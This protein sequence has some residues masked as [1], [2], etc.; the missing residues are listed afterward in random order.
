[1]TLGRC[2]LEK[3]LGIQIP[4]PGSFSRV[5]VAK[6]KMNNVVA[7]A[8]EGHEIVR[9]AL[10]ALRDGDDVMHLVHRGQPTFFLAAFT[11]RV[12]FDI[13]ITDTFPRA[14]I[15]F[16]D[17]LVAGVFVVGLVGFLFMF[18][19][20]LTV[21]QL[22]TAGVCTGTLRFIWHRFTSLRA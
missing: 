4:P 11:E 22:W 7:R 9:R 19:T 13:A 17:V 6:L 5:P 14:A 21:R 16:V 20:V 8:A 12:L 1:M 15:G 2:P 18:C 3:V 10:T